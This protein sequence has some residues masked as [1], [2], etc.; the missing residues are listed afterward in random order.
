MYTTSPEDVLAIVSK[1]LKA[2]HLSQEKVAELTGYKSRQAISLILKSQK[3][4]NESQAKAF[5][6]AFGYYEGFLTQG[7][8]S[9]MSDEPD[10]RQVAMRSSAIYPEAILNLRPFEDKDSFKK[11]FDQLLETM[12]L[13]YG[14][15]NVRKLLV[16]CVR[17][18]DVFIDVKEEHIERMVQRRRQQGI[19]NTKEE[20][21][22]FRK[23]M[24]A[25]DYDEYIER[26]RH[27]LLN[28]MYDLYMQLSEK[29]L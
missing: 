24:A 14:E 7:D 29:C 18:F 6:D 11:A 8:G 13:V 28:S 2:R 26:E 4:M 17:Y 25:K 27:R 1:D 9:L 21:D 16:T 12:I 22:D 23:R 10:P 19:F 15:L 3:Y 20:E 5:H